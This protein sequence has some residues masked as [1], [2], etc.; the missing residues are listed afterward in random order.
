[1][2]KN[3]VVAEILLINLVV[4]NYKKQ[5]INLLE[6]IISASP[7]NILRILKQV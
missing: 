1:M 5:D 6:M 4:V 3:K 2:L 7:K